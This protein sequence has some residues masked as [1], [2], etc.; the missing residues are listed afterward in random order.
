MPD[1]WTWLTI[2]AAP[3]LV[4]ELYAL[5]RYRRRL[6]LDFRKQGLRTLRPAQKGEWK[7]AM[8]SEEAGLPTHEPFEAWGGVFQQP[9]GAVPATTGEAILCFDPAGRCTT[10]NLAAHE[11]LRWSPE[12]TM[13]SECLGGG[14]Q[15]LAAVAHQGVVELD[16]VV[17]TLP[18]P[19]MFR[20]RAVALRDRD[21]N[22]WGAAVFIHPPAITPAGAASPPPPH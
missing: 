4:L 15:I 18:S 5:H 14:A 2:G 12:Q 17:S 21:N 8:E 10:A 13:L 11:L 22:F 20:I 19:A 1:I 9:A 16:A 7:R 6:R 3:A